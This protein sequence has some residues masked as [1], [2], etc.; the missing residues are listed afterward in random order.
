MALKILY[1]YRLTCKRKKKN[2]QRG[3]Q[4]HYALLDTCKAAVLQTRSDIVACNP[5]CESSQ[6]K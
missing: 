5:V 6:S 2:L 3:D 4:S 1:P